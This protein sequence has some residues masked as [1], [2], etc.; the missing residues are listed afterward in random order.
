MIINIYYCLVNFKFIAYTDA[1]WHSK[2]VLE[3]STQLNIHINE[4]MKYYVHK[5]K[6]R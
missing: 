3:I 5:W 6:Y 4:H 2:Y 1:K